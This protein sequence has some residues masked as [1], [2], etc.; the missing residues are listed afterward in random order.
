MSK[1]RKK[2]MARERLVNEVS[3]LWLIF[4]LL[5]SFYY[6]YQSDKEKNSSHF[7]YA[8]YILRL[9][10]SSFLRLTVGFVNQNAPLKL[11]LFPLHGEHLQEQINTKLYSSVAGTHCTTVHPVVPCMRLGHDLEGD[12]SEQSV[13]CLEKFNVHSNHILQ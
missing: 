10:W 2:I 12:H 11:C 4:S 1:K 9:K 13:T 7:V 5:L 6:T 3:W 8:L